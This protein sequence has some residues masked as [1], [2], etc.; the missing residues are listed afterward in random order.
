M[1]NLSKLDFDVSYGTNF[2]SDEANLIDVY[3]CK[4]SQ[5][6]EVKEDDKF[7]SFSANLIKC[8]KSKIKESP[9]KLRVDSLIDTYKAAE[10]TYDKKTDYTLSEWCMANVNRFLGIAEGRDFSLEELE[11]NKE[12]IKKDLEKYNLNLDFESVDELYIETRKEAINQAIASQWME[13]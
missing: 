8:F 2:S 3:E 12:E 7:V 11:V 9:A 10:E 4:K 6:E 5:K 13:F 1:D